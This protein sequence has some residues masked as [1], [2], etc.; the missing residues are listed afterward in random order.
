MRQ[1]FGSRLKKLESVMKPVE[2]EGSTSSQYCSCPVEPMVR[3]ILPD[4]DRSE[5]QLQAL[6]TAVSAPRLCGECGRQMLTVCRTI[7]PPVVT[8]I[9]DHLDT[10]GCE[11][12]W[13]YGQGVEG[14]AF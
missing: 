10:L 3:I 13:G 11:M 8:P 9:V 2:T 12:E 5:E 4:V 7:E 14:R 6:L 1:L